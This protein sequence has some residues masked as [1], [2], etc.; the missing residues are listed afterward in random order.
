MASIICD[1]TDKIGRFYDHLNYNL[2]DIKDMRIVYG[3]F[4]RLAIDKAGRGSNIDEYCEDDESREAYTINPLPLF[5][6]INAPAHLDTYAENFG[7]IIDEPERMQLFASLAIQPQYC[8]TVLR[9]DILRLMQSM[10][11]EYR[12]AINYYIS[13]AMFL[14]THLYESTWLTYEQCLL[15]DSFARA[16]PQM[17]ND[18]ARIL[19]ADPRGLSRYN[20]TVA[21]DINSRFHTFT[22]DLFRDLSLPGCYFS[23]SILCAVLCENPLEFGMTYRDYVDHYYGNSDIDIIVET[24]SLRDVIDAL[25]LRLAEFAPKLN[26]VR[27]GSM[28]HT[29]EFNEKARHYNIV[30]NNG[31][32]VDVYQ[33]TAAAVKEYHVP[34]VRGV[35]ELVE[36]KATVK[37]LPTCLTSIISGNMFNV[38]YHISKK[39]PYLAVIQKYMNRG[40]GFAANKDIINLLPVEQSRPYNESSNDSNF[41]TISTPIS[42]PIS[43]GGNSG[44]N[45]AI[46]R[47]VNI[48]TDTGCYPHMPNFN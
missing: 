5:Y 39:N 36:G 42:T 43:T 8:R 34:M 38:K 30:L 25:M 32:N 1:Y 6:D 35:I 17:Y 4:K 24:A 20:M 41:R 48:Y 37:V 28:Q 9:E 46:Y 13:R 40:F 33:S 27:S 47:G 16:N 11:G 7:I 31:M 2:R 14:L 12:H 23:G 22:R 26:I 3:S 45:A 21:T 44:G 15:I 29:E 10:S 18:Y 19:K